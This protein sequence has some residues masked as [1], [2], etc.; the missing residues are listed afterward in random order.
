ML[1]I[2]SLPALLFPCSACKFCPSSSIRLVVTCIDAAIDAAIST[3]L[4]LASSALSP[5]NAFVL[6]AVDT[7]LH[8][9]EIRPISVFEQRRSMN[10]SQ[11]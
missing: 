7:A 6:R 8:N 5:S 4:L 1:V 10:G 3:L 9:F 2:A 11:P